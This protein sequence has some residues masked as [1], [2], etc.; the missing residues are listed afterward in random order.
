MHGCD[1]ANVWI[2]FCGIKASDSP[3]KKY[4]QRTDAHLAFSNNCTLATQVYLF[5]SRVD[6]PIQLRM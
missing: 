1:E 4:H 6:S 3:S 2:S 5:S